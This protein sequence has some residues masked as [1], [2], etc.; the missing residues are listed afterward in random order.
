VVTPW[1]NQNYN[2]GISTR[3]IE[4]KYTTYH[5]VDRTEVFGSLEP[6]KFLPNERKGGLQYNLAIGSNVFV[7]SKDT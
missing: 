3:S 5:Q 7:F 6:H 2:K 1:H 4:P